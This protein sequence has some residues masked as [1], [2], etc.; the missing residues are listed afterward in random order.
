M[1]A[2]TGTDPENPRRNADANRHH[3]SERPGGR[4]ETSGAPCKPFGPL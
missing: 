4:T 2:P 1:T 3:R